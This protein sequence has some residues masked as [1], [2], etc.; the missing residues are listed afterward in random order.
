MGFTLAARDF[1]DNYI[2]AVEGW[3]KRR[4]REGGG[5]PG[6]GGLHGDISRV[7][8]HPGPADALKIKDKVNEAGVRLE[9][10][11]GSRGSGLNQ[12]KDN[13]CLLYTSPSPRDA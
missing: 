8:L 13:I 1:V 10:E 12:Q 5:G 4:E 6:A 3:D 11:L 9:E 7:R 2:P